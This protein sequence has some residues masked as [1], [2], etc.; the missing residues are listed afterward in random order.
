MNHRPTEQEV[1]VMQL[2]FRRYRELIS[3]SVSINHLCP[4]YCTKDSLMRLATEAI[5]NT[6]RYPYDKLNRW[7]GFIQGILAV[8]CVIDV[9]AER[10]YTRPLFHSLNSQPIPS[11]P[12]T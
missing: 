10:D 1:Q 6:S 11:F 12:E 2:L 7:L 8:K 5:E 9:D 4:A 3:Q